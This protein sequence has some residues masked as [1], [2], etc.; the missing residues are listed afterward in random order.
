MAS[1][2]RAGLG[3][4]QSRVTVTSIALFDDSTIRPT[5]EISPSRS[6]SSV[7]A[8]SITEGDRLVEVLAVTPRTDVALRVER[9][10]AQR[11]WRPAGPDDPRRPR[12]E[13]ARGVGGHPDAQEIRSVFVLVV[14]LIRVDLLAV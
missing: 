1:R 12:H 11:A 2:T 9:R 3:S 4:G 13:G 5:M 14:V 7:V 10:T 8:R 6:A